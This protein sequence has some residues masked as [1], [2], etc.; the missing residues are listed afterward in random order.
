[1]TDYT[2]LKNKPRTQA[3][4][5][6]SDIYQRARDLEVQQIAERAI[7]LAGRSA[8]PDFLGEVAVKIAE[9]A[10]KKGRTV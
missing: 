10:Q 2:Q 5:E 1:M 3:R 4:G 9:I 8:S 6:L 7:S